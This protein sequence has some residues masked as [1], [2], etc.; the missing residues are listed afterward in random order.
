[1]VNWLPRKPNTPLMIGFAVAMTDDEIRD[2]AEY[3]SSMPWTAWIEVIEADSVPKTYPSGGMHLRHEG[4][5]AGMEAIGRRIIET[6]V[7]TEH[8]ELLRNPRSSFIAYVPPGS[9]ARGEALARGSKT[10]AC[11]ACHG[12][13]LDGLAVVPG[14]RGRS[15][16]YLARQLVDM[17]EGKRRGLW[18]PL[19][20]PVV[21]DLSADDILNLAAYLSSLP[22]VP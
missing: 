16:S 8:T 1:M 9:I 10:T 15:P 7:N 13:S 14:L 3:F 6:P 5:A 4:A 2:A 11:A 18:A 20:A 12:E 21:A 22:P 17:K 19:M